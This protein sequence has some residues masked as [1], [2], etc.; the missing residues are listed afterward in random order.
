MHGTDISVPVPVITGGRG[1]GALSSL[2]H[3]DGMIDDAARGAWIHDACSELR[4]GPRSR[5]AYRSQVTTNVNNVRTG[6]QLVLPRSGVVQSELS[7]CQLE[8]NS[9]NRAHGAD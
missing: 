8:I 5:D 6:Q 9:G 2:M 4:A 7:T 3:L 1:G